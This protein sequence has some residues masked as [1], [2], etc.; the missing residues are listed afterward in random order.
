MNR[1]FWTAVAERSGDTALSSNVT[2]NLN[3]PLCVRTEPK[4]AWR[5]K[6][7]PAQ[8]AFMVLAIFSRFR[9]KRTLFSSAVVRAAWR[10]T[11][12]IVAQ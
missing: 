1:Q 4:E 11:T 5:S 6:T 7:L 2:A 9:S 3:Y 10:I 12:E 8:F